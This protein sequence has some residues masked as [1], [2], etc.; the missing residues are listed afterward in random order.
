[1]DEQVAVSGENISGWV[2]GLK[3]R[4]QVSKWMS[5]WYWYGYDS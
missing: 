4:L 3:N 1:V 5:K 2:C